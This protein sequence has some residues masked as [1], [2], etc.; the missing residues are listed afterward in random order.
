MAVHQPNFSVGRPG[1]LGTGSW[2]LTDLTD[3]TVLFGRNGAG[4]SQL[5]RNIRDQNRQSRH[6]ASPERWGEIAF[7]AT[8]M[9][10]ELSPSSRGNR[11][12][13]NTAPTYRDEGVARIQAFLARRGNVR[14]DPAP[15]N[16]ELLE[17]LMNQL[18]PSFEFT[19]SG[20]GVPYQ[21]TRRPTGESV[22]NSTVLSSGE[23][24]IFSFG[25]DLVTI[26][27]LWALDGD[28]VGILLL[29]EPDLHLHPDLQEH[30]ASF[31]V[32]LVRVF[33]VQVLVATHSTTLLSA[34][35]HYGG[36]K[37]TIIYLDNSVDDQ[38]SFR[39]NEAA[40]ELATCL[41]GHALMGPLFALPLLLVEGDDD[42][43]V[44]SHAGRYNQIRVAVIPCEGS[45]MD[46]YV[47]ML[48]RIFKAIVESR[49]APLAFA[50]RDLDDR[51]EQPR[52]T[53]TFVQR[54]WLDC[55]EVENLYLTDEALQA[56]GTDWAKASQSIA[57]RA[58]EF[59][60]KQ[61]QLRKISSADR[62]TC[63]L[64]G[65]MEQL[66]AILDS[67]KRVDWR[68][69]IGQVIGRSKPNGQLAQ[70]LGDAVIAA[71]WPDRMTPSVPD[72]PVESDG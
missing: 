32:E 4:K 21:L 70:F 44:W 18:M 19:I 67:P 56:L 36:D 7:N 17:R 53:G 3:V 22:P 20:E 69:R 35:G 15:V 6:Y 64:K 31:I 63:D 57:A 25:L 51:S 26:C 33:D 30:L 10:E 55:H 24:A 27:G 39:F 11:R 16:P 62:R 71:L 34:L 42:Y 40:Q 9:Q 38:K 1:W 45:R 41:G 12:Q 8:Y 37:T 52:P 23:V 58:A 72:A 43:K 68:I 46:Q 59:G 48:D 14:A 28:P 60:E 61:D 29:D 54:I 65:V 50:L 49:K 47:A 5:L 13:G 2:K 66:T